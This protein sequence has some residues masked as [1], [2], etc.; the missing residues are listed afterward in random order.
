MRGWITLLLIVLIGSLSNTVSGQDDKTGDAPSAINERFIVEGTVYDE[1]TG[2]PIPGATVQTIGH[3]AA[4][5]ANGDGKYRLIL[6]V[7]D[8]T[9]KVTHVGH[10][11][12]KIS[13]GFDPA[14]ADSGKTIVRDI[15]LKP[16]IID[17]GRRQVF[18]RAYDP[19]QKIIA[20]AIS[21]KKDILSRFHDYSY[22]AY[23]KLI[24]RDASKTD[25]TDIFVIA[26]TQTTS[27]WEQP[28]K[29]KEIISSRRQ[30]AN[31]PAEG[32]L[33][34]VGEMLNFNKNR[35][36]LGEYNVVSPTA[37]DA[38]DNY[39]YY[40]L[41]TVYIDEKAVFVLEV[42]PKNEYG[43]LFRGEIYIADSTYDVVKVDVG[44]SKGLTF[45]FLS[46]ARYYQDFAPV[47][48][49]FWLPV[50]IGFSGTIDINIP[51]PGIPRVIDF[52]RVASIYSYKID[53]R[54]PGNTFGEYVLEV[55]RKADEFD[56]TAWASRQTIPLTENELFGYHRIDSLE[57][58]P[59]PLYKRLLLG[60]AV[61]TVVYANGLPDFYHYNRVE[62][63]YLGLGGKPDIGEDTKLRLK[64]GY[65]FGT[66]EWQYE[67]G[68]KRQIWRG[69][70]LWVG[71]S[72]KDEIVARPAIASG[73]NFNPTANSYFFKID[74]LDYYREKGYTV[75]ASIKPVNQ[76]RFSLTY[77]DFNQ[78]SQSINAHHSIFR[79]SVSRRGNPSIIDGKM[80][81]ITAK[82]QYDSRK[83]INNKGREMYA[84]ADTYFRIEPGFEIASPDLID[85][86]FDFRRYFVRLE[87]ETWLFDFGRTTLTGYLGSSDGDLPPQRYFS[88]DFHDPNFFKD[89]NFNTL[90][91]SN[92]GGDRVASIYLYHNFGKFMFRNSGIDFLKGIPF[93]FAVN[94]GVFW[95]EFSHTIPPGNNDYI[96]TAPTAYSEIG[97]GFTNLTPFLNPF[98]IALTFTWQLSDY[99]TYRFTSMFELRL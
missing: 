80:R 61:A 93:G 75:S 40:L 18:T 6:P 27:Y 96:M 92:F 83:L 77:G 67:F 70:K 95:S 30:S 9:L 7:G 54:L 49:D 68:L 19:A 82:A 17:L 35:I 78:D 57:A 60:M 52:E 25:S 66:E 62:G 98:N 76:T 84:N 85:N 88:M 29:Y 31:I 91:E 69:Q 42:E 55:D 81:T 65:A 87:V 1:A 32:N 63:Q 89:Q 15:T 39:N 21:R 94:G 8:Y 10:Y 86:D 46:N 51:I 2:E 3:N 36:E 79:K 16:L 20:T 44:F 12:G 64:T 99:D 38:I 22:D 53:K 5:P 24:L 34:A 45:P 37:E 90:F 43:P 71:A 48:G 72:L 4:T 73:P 28:D 56:S 74:P 26:E 58:I 14:Q 47:D 11:S 59:P 41:D 23:T 33:V 50:Q 97:F 13:I